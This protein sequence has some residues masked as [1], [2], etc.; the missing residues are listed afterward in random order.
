MRR[1]FAI[2]VCVI[3]SAA[4]SSSA[5]A[6]PDPVAHPNNASCLG[7]RDAGGSP[8]A[9]QDWGGFY[10]TQS[11]DN[12]RDDINRFYREVLGTHPLGTGLIA[13]YAQTKNEPGTC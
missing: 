10:G 12:A 13:P 7:N 1:L 5:A 6:G 8:A 9:A 2:V 11:P 4:M 3:A